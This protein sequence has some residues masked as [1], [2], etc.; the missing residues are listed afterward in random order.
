MVMID[1]NIRQ[2]VIQAF[3]SELDSGAT[4]ENLYKGFTTASRHTPENP[5]FEMKFGIKAAC[6]PQ[7]VHDAFISTDNPHSRLMAHIHLKATYSECQNDADD[8]LFATTNSVN[9]LGLDGS[10]GYVFE[11]IQ[12]L[13]EGEPVD[14]EDYN[15]IKLS[16]PD[17]L[18][19][20]ND[21]LELV[22]AYDHPSIFETVLRY[23]NEHPF[24]NFCSTLAD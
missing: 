24:L 11:L 2:A 21:L 3:T 10:F 9:S 16:K 14:D 23:H 15:R 13:T 18:L 22:S 6:L 5:D 8:N 19:L 17:E 12:I 7:T 4:K 1:T 20:A